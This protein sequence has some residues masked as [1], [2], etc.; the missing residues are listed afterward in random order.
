M[1]NQTKLHTSEFIFKPAALSSSITRLT[2]FINLRFVTSLNMSYCDGGVLEL[3]SRPF[4]H[5]FIQPTENGVDWEGGGRL[6]TSAPAGR[7]REPEPR[8]HLLGQCIQVRERFERIRLVCELLEQCRVLNRVDEIV[9]VLRCQAPWCGR[10]FAEAIG[11]LVR[12]G[13]ILMP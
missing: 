9:R 1:S 13:S 11:V 12:R 5:S 4:I 6:S 7:R 3:M 8:T 10:E 2:A